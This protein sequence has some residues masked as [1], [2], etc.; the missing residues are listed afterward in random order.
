MSYRAT[1]DDWKAARRQ[2]GHTQQQAAETIG[3]PVRTYQD[4]ELGRGAAYRAVLEYYLL[5]TGQRAS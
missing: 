1:S 3:V 4:W 2:A 5:R